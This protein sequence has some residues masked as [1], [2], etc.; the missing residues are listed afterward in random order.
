MQWRINTSESNKFILLLKDEFDHKCIWLINNQKN[1]CLNHPLCSF[2]NIK[3]GLNSKRKQDVII[4]DV[5]SLKDLHFDDK[6]ITE[7]QYRTSQN[8]IPHLLRLELMIWAYPMTWLYLDQS[9]ELGELSV[10]THLTSNWR[11][12]RDVPVLQN[13]LCSNN[14]YITQLQIKQKHFTFSTKKS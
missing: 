3:V 5:N 2:P 12:L 8:L 6:Y 13:L 7:S 4:K 14:S 9:I 10:K 11:H 1:D